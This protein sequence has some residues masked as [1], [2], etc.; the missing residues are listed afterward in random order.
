MVTSMEIEND[1]LDILGQQPG[2]H[3]LYTQICSIYAVPDSSN[4]DTIINTL[5]NGLDELTE[6]IPWLA[7]EVINE[8]ASERNTG[9]YKIIRTERIPLIVKDHQQDTSAP[10]MN[11]LRES[12]FPIS[13]LHENIIAPC[14]TIN[15]PGNTVGL[16][17]HSA[18]VFAVQ[19]NFITGGL[20]LTFVGQHDVMDMTG[21]DAIIEW[22]DNICH[23]TPLT[24]EDISIG[25]MDRTKTVSLFGDDYK[26]GP[27][28][29]EQMIRPPPAELDVSSTPT[30]PAPS[31]WAYI[32]FSVTALESLKIDATK[33]M[34]LPSGFISTDDALCAFIWKC[35][36]RAR[37]PCLAP[38]TK[39]SFA[40]AV[41]IRQ[42]MGLPT[43][44][45]GMFQ[46]MT[47]QHDTLQSLAEKPLGVIASEFRRQLDPKVRDLVYNAREAGGSSKT[48]V[49]AF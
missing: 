29:D 25:N 19:A 37:I 39:S 48:G 28:L 23:G 6:S 47:Y 42:R 24:Q 43:S 32:T 4:F 3:K 2:M 10:T 18:P 26:P 27:E 41:D 13:M 33:T 17:A 38:N 5:R 12:N 34:T 9:V 44:Y 22:L 45:P 20:I 1:V 21:Q 35:V 14:L 36:S 46:N 16:A 49:Y 8:G 11:A 7:G 31:T 15:L 30:T 40:R